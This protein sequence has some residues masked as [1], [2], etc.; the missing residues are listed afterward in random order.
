M[1][2]CLKNSSILVGMTMLG[3]DLFCTVI[4]FLF[5]LQLVYR[6]LGLVFAG[7]FA[8]FAGTHS[9]ALNLPF[10]RTEK[11]ILIEFSSGINFLALWGLSQPFI[12]SYA[13][14]P[15][16]QSSK[17]ILQQSLI[18]KLS[19]ATT[20]EHRLLTIFTKSSPLEKFLGMAVQYTWPVLEDDS[21]IS[22]LMDKLRIHSMW[23]YDGPTSS[24]VNHAKWHM[25]ILPHLSSANNSKLALIINQSLLVQVI[26]CNSSSLYFWYKYSRW[27]S[28]SLHATILKLKILSFPWN[29]SIHPQ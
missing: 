10:S 20:C 7:R 26:M 9:A 11:Y 1:Y 29:L 21:L 24:K 4:Y 25:K 17:V 12:P 19:F 16:I 23:W 3:L 15:N 13:G 2:E 18:L 6:G 5:V 14:L 27:V 28:P 8:G 22:N